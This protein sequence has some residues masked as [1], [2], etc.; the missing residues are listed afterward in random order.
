MFKNIFKTKA[1]NQNIITLTDFENYGPKQS[2][3]GLHEKDLA[4][5]NNGN[6]DQLHLL[7][8]NNSFLLRDLK[9]R[10]PNAQIHIHGNKNV[11]V[12]NCH[13]HSLTT[14]AKHKVQIEDS[15]I[16]F[17]HM[18]DAYTIDLRNSMSL[19]TFT[20][21][22][23]SEIQLS[24][25]NAQLGADVPL[26]TVMTGHNVNSF[27][28]ANDS[29]KPKQI[30]NLYIAPELPYTFDKVVVYNGNSQSFIRGNHHYPISK[31]VASAEKIEQ[32]KEYLLSNMSIFKQGASKEAERIIHNFVDAILEINPSA[33]GS[34][35]PKKG[36]GMI[37]CD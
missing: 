37:I 2:Y 1:M 32:T 24:H 18:S 22:N 5:L 20:C 7:S 14:N 13:A 6:F 3:S 26:L 23:A 33:Q 11:I 36:K 17:S 31:Q 16:T 21:P 27:A 8:T 30:G 9:P 15:E 34:I 35:A 12:Q 28:P 29:A 4:E 25:T 10:N 19:M